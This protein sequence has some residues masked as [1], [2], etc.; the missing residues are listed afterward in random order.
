[1][2]LSQ[3]IR[4]ISNLTRL[5]WAYFALFAGVVIIGHLPGVNDSEGRLFGLFHITLY[6][7]LLHSFSGVWVAAAA[8]VSDKA[9]RTY[10]RW[11]GTIYFLD[12]VLGAITGVTF[13]DFG[14]FTGKAPID[15]TLTRILANAPHIAI[16]GVAMLAGFVW[17]KRWMAS[18]GAA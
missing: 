3:R 14:I 18:K 13:L 4:D 5:G 1:M 15:G 2:K 16:G 7:D 8:M 10:F 9:V 17:A 12:G 11:F 6:Q